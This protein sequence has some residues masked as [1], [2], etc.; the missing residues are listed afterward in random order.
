MAERRRPR[1]PEGKQRGQSKFRIDQAKV[2]IRKAEPNIRY[3]DCACAL[4]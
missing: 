4:I 1:M 3:D 2:I